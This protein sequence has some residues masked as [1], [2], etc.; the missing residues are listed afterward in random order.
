MVVLLLVVDQTH[1][2][3]VFVVNRK[4]VDHAPYAACIVNKDK[5]WEDAA[6]AP[7]DSPFTRLL[8]YRDALLLQHKRAAK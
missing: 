1:R 5:S 4:L 2:G 6:F 8:Q 3:V 7:P